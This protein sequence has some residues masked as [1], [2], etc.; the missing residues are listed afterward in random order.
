LRPHAQTV[1]NKKSDSLSL[2]YTDVNAVRTVNALQEDQSRADINL[3]YDEEEG[4]GSAQNASP[5]KIEG[6]AAKKSARNDEA[7]GN[8]VIDMSTNK[9]NYEEPD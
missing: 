6:K 8:M 3:G 7:E 2:G 5:L 1:L 9:L 4:G